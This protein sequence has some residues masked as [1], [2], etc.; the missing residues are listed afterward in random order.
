MAATTQVKSDSNR[1]RKGIGAY[2]L[3]DRA[4]R[5]GDMGLW[6]SDRGLCCIG[7]YHTYKQG[8]SIEVYA[9]PIGSINKG[10]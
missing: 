5:D 9:N 3:R 2:G 4:Y 10:L 6:K 8:L 1:T 7:V